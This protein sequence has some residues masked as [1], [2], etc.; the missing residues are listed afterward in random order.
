MAQ[1]TTVSPLA[2]LGF[3]ILLAGALSASALLSA[4]RVRP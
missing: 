1:P 3:A 2:V 4:R